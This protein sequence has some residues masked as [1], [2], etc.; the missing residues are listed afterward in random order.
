MQVKCVPGR[1]L[2]FGQIITDPILAKLNAGS[3]TTCSGESPICHYIRRSR[4]VQ[5][6]VNR[7]KAILSKVQ[8]NNRGYNNTDNSPPE[9]CARVAFHRSQLCAMKVLHKTAGPSMGSFPT[10]RQ[11]KDPISGAR[12]TGCQRRL[13]VEENQTVFDCDARQSGHVV[14]IQL[15]HQTGPVLFY[16]LHADRHQLSDGI[17]S[18]P[19]R[20]EL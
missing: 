1:T 10:F 14:N 11:K 20:D 2:D 8:T 7:P 19:F 4:C 13:L 17:V 12:N 16:G 15:V 18:V 3:P 9:V 5:G 6:R